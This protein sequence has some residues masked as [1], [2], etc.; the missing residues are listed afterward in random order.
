MTILYSS[1][2]Y[3]E[4]Q[5]EQYSKAGKAH[6]IHR[7]GHLNVWL[8]DDGQIHIDPINSQIQEEGEHVCD[9]IRL[10]VKDAEE[11]ARELLTAVDVYRTEYE[12]AGEDYEAYAEARSGSK[13]T[14]ENGWDPEYP[15]TS[16]VF[17]ADGNCLG[18]LM[19]IDPEAIRNNPSIQPWSKPSA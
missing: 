19:S 7:E 15:E 18:R 9:A 1:A 8:F 3:V 13:L 10:S 16:L 4:C 14:A 11:F 2:Q 5:I 17:D 6:L 12:E